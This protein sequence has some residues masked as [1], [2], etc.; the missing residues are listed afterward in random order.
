M[1]YGD[2]D[3]PDWETHEHDLSRSM[4]K[5]AEVGL[6][7]VVLGSG[8]PFFARPRPRLRLV[9]NDPIVEDVIRL[10]YVPA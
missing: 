10:T 8:E 2:D 3:S 7:P 6:Q 5:P 9:A 1:R 4:A